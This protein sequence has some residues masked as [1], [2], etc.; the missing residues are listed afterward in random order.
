MDTGGVDVATRSS[1]TASAINTFIATR[2]HDMDACR[3]IES[4]SF[5]TTFG[6]AI[7]TA[8]RIL[9]MIMNA[10]G[11]ES[12]ARTVARGSTEYAIAII[13]EG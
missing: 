4:A 5:A 7:S 11:R 1:V 8:F 10:R 13:H 9:W 3:R 12:T 6:G 2:P